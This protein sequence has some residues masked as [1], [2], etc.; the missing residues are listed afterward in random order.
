M[1]QSYNNLA[2]KSTLTLVLGV[3]LFS[4]T[5]VSAMVPNDLEYSKQQ[6]MWQQIGAQKAWDYSIGSNQV[7]VAVIDTGADIWHDDLKQNI[8]TNPYEVPD[9]NYDDDNNGYV[10]DAH[11]WNFIENNNDVRTGVLDNTN[12][13]EAI[14]HGTV[15][16]GLIGAVGDNHESGVGLNWKVKIMPLRAIDSNGNGSYKEVYKAIAYAIDNDAD[17]IS[18]SVVGSKFDESLKN[19]LRSAY[20]KGIVVIAAAGNDQLL[21]NGNLTSNHYYP[22]CLDSDSA[23]NWIIGVSSVDKNDKL[24]K[25]ANYGSC[26]DVVAPGEDIYSTQRYAPVYGYD[27]EFAGPWQGTS[28]SV[29]LVAGAAALLKA[30]H[31]DWTAPKIISALLKNSDDIFAQNLSF[32]NDLGFGRLNIGKALENSVNDPSFP[33]DYSSLENYYFKADTIYTKKDN[34]NYFFAS[35]GEAKIIHLVGSRSSNNKHDEVFV[36]SVRGKHYFVQFFNDQ[37][38]KWKEV[39]VPLA[40]YTAKKL[41]TKIKILND[42]TGRKIQLEFLEN[43]KKS[44]KKIVKKVSTKQYDWLD[45]D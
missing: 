15:I 18:L 39:A 43:I 30:V 8:W 45:N 3:F 40:D 7:T 22:V 38:R 12:D 36:L 35:V 25:F 33:I 21:G 4:A 1:I 6:N 14:A 2:K 41:P 5:Q 11:G 13:P 27:K 31:L 34:V 20:D 42:S 28:F 9:N 37:G 16:A 17:I 26:V 32:P 24:S 10:D 19:I 44:K 29:P 23:E